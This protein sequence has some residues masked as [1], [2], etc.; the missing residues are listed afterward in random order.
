MRWLLTLTCAAAAAYFAMENLR[1]RRARE[2]VQ[3]A[4][5]ACPPAPACLGGER[6]YG[7]GALAA[8]RPPFVRPTRTPRDGA[9][10]AAQQAIDLLHASRRGAE[11]HLHLFARE[12]ALRPEQI[13][14]AHQIARDIAD[15]LETRTAALDPAKAGQTIAEFE[16]LASEAEDRFAALLDEPQRAI[17]QKSEFDFAREVLLLDD[18]ENPPLD[19]ALMPRAAP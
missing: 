16:T 12:A 17:Y 15:M 3:V 6:A 10:L 2:T 8:L 13:A 18:R 11:E 1:L 5:P 9:D 14:R 19:A 7:P 4:P